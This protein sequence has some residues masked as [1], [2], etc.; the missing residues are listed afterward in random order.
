MPG[1]ITGK[2]AIDALEQAA[3]R[4]E[5]LGDYSPVFHDDQGVRYTS[6]AFQ[7]CL[8]S[9]GIAQSVSRPGNPW[10]NAP[11]AS[12][13]KTLK[14]GLVKERTYETREKAKQ[15]IFKY[16]EPCCNTQR[17]HSSLGCRAPC[18]LERGVA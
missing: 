10:D 15:D 9:H 13:F 4:E 18:D 11:A 14:R 7:R 6:R 1:R 17:M 12:F 5:P 8:E 16:I 3:G 2:L